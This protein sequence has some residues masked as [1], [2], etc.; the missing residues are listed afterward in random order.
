MTFTTATKLSEG[1]TAAAHHLDAL[2]KKQKPSI[3]ARMDRWITWNPA[4]TTNASEQ[5]TPL[6]EKGTCTACLVGA[7]MIQEYSALE[8]VAAHVDTLAAA[9]EPKT[10]NEPRIALSVQSAIGDADNG[11]RNKT[12]ARLM[13]MEDARWGRWWIAMLTAGW[14]FDGDPDEVRARLKDIRAPQPMFN[15]QMSDGEVIHLIADIQNRVVP[16]LEAA[17]A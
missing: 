10:E 7:I 12:I 14:S 8:Q 17:G 9:P 3:T 16:E 13:S 15:G 2:L 5:P 4:E 1:L 11:N 6:F